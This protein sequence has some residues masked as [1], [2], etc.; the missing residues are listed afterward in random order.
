MDKDQILSSIKDEMKNFTALENTLTATELLTNG[1]LFG[2]GLTGIEPVFECATDDEFD[3]K[4]KALEDATI[5]YYDKTGVASEI[6]SGFIGANYKSLIK[7]LKKCKEKMDSGKAKQKPQKIA[8]PVHTYFTLPE[9][10]KTYVLTVKVVGIVEKLVSELEKTS[11][12]D[13]D[14]AEK[15]KKF[16]SN[17]SGVITSINKISGEVANSDG[18]KSEIQL[19]SGTLCIAGLSAPAFGIYET[20]RYDPSKMVTRSASEMAGEYDKV[21]T[22]INKFASLNGTIH[23]IKARALR[24]S[25]TNRKIAKGGL[26]DK[27]KEIRKN[28][29]NRAELNTYK[30]G[31]TAMDVVSKQT[32]S[33]ARYLTKLSGMAY[34]KVSTYGYSTMAALSAHN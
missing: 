26:K 20:V 3:E 2:T 15:L 25:D 12:E 23:Q 10:E 21:V 7:V 1:F 9:L 18:V 33:I 14:S 16:T 17:I 29:G 32:V 22:L 4:Y 31:K 11:S 5:S 30:Y 6:T 24:I 13:V 34:S 19:Q 8:Q 28:D 27:K